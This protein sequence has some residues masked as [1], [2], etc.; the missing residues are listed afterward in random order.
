[1]FGGTLDL[2]TNSITVASLSGSAGTIT[3]NSSAAGTSTL[4][5]D[6]FTTTSYAGTLADGTTRHLALS[7]SGGARLAAALPIPIPAARRLAPAR[8]RLATPRP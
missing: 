2:N 1:M 3:D 7:F 4:T 8:L 6:Q 5:V